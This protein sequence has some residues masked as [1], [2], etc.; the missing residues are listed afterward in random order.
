MLSESEKKGEEGLVETVTVLAL[1]TLTVLFFAPSAEADILDQ[2]ATAFASGDTRE[3]L[4][5]ISSPVETEIRL[6]A[7]KNRLLV[8]NEDELADSV[9]TET[10]YRLYR[11]RGELHKAHSVLYTFIHRHPQRPLSFLYLYWMAKDEESRSNH[12]SA[13][14][15]FGQVALRY[16]ENEADPYRLRLRAWRNTGLN[17]HHNQGRYQEAI[18]V[19]QNLLLLFPDYEG[20][21]EIWYLIATCYENEGM[22]EK[23]LEGYRRILEI[24]PLS[25]EE[26]PLF[27]LR[28]L[29]QLRIDYL[30]NPRVE[31]EDPHIL[32]LYLEEAFSGG[33]IARIASLAKLGDFW[34]GTMFSEKKV[35]EFA[36]VRAYLER[37]LPKSEMIFSREEPSPGRYRLRIEGWGDPEYD[38]LYLGVEK[39][40]FGWEWR[41]VIISSSDLEQTVHGTPAG[42]E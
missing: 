19:Y 5:L 26:H 10:L 38:R 24:L 17:L 21:A 40:L 2:A 13:I 15:L 20:K 8:K 31:T 6:V 36:D 4:A 39:G 33:D 35:G 23:A 30:T 16:P 22:I 41:E 25:F 11:E 3:G 18:G 28:K 32:L 14:S 27:H 12:E 9:L 1:A 29:A 42:E 34:Y 7:E 37:F